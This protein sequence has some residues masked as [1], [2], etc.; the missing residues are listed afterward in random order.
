MM[1]MPSAKDANTLPI[2][3]LA[4]SSE[5]CLS[6]SCSSRLRPICTACIMAATSLGADLQLRRRSMSGKL[7]ANPMPWGLKMA[8]ASKPVEQGK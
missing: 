5:R 8:P 2:R 7:W 6:A 3:L 4:F 1:L